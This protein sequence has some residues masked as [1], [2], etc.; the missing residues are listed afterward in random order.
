MKMHILC[1]KSKQ[2]TASQLLSGSSFAFA[3][4]WVS[5]LSLHN[6][7]LSLKGLAEALQLRPFPQK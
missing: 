7:E 2:Q 3:T 4:I 5:L 6:E 1:L